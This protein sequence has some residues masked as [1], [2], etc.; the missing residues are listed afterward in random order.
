M[1]AY[2]VL[3]IIP[4]LELLLPTN[5]GIMGWCPDAEGLYAILFAIVRMFFIPFISPMPR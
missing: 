1:A 2:M 5:Y 4:I 3:Y